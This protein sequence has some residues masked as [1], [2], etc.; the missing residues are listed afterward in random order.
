MGLRKRIHKKHSS[1]FARN[2]L[3]LLLISDRV[4]CSGEIMEKIRMDII[5]AI[6]KYIEINTEELEIQILQI[7]SENGE[8]TFPA[9]CANIP[10]R[11]MRHAGQ[12]NV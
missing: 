11:N 8:V 2:R 3:K 10:I 12:I 5:E 6:S 4:N 1:D 7:K 9:L